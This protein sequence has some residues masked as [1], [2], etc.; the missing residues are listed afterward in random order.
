MQRRRE[1]HHHLQELLHHI[2]ILHVSRLPN[3][4]LGP[5]TQASRDHPKPPTPLNVERKTFILRA[6]E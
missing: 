4:K 3:A 2:I 6:S 5:A 1:G